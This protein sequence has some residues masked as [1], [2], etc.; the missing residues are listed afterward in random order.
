MNTHTPDQIPSPDLERLFFELFEAY[1]SPIFR[2]VY[3]QLRER[4]QALDITQE[5]F[6]HTWQYLARGRELENPE[7]FLYRS[8][9]NA[10]IDFYKKKKALSLDGLLDDGFEPGN[11]EMEHHL[12]END[13]S[14][15]TGLIRELNPKD[16]QIILLRYM[17]ERP[18]EEIAE[19]FGKTANAMTV[20][21]HRIIQ[22]L[23][24]LYEEK[25][26]T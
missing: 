8:A 19:Q 12:K 17:E 23:K 7:A 3:F 18:I 9:R 24:R 1:R 13:L 2:F 5:V 14:V 20:H 16:S 15:L 11:D 6:M 22:K 10:V 25:H 21:I 4:Q 26:G